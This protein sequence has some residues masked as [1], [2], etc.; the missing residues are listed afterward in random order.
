MASVQLLRR[1]RIGRAAFLTFGLALIRSVASVGRAALGKATPWP[2]HDPLFVRALTSY[3]LSPTTPGARSFSFL[4]A[5]TCT[6]AAASLAFH[7]SARMHPLTI[8]LAVALNLWSSALI[9]LAL[10]AALALALRRHIRG[11]NLA[12]DRAIRRLV[13]TAAA[14]AAGTAGVALVAAGAAT[15][16]PPG[17]R[18]EFWFLGS[19]L[20]LAG[21]YPV[22]LLAT[23]A[24]RGKA[25]SP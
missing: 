19:A 11:F 12:T 15:A 13:H 25:A 1:H 4:A 8:N 22:T 23:L 16:C 17:T 20:P 3:H 7:F 9:D 24:A 18:G 21:L 5:C 2:V 14:T 6:I 10:A